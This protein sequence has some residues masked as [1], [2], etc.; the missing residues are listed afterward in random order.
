MKLM[1]LTATLGAFGAVTVALTAIVAPARAADSVQV[2]GTIVNLDGSKLTVKTREGATTAVAL[3]EGWELTG[4]AKAA[5]DDIK[6]GEF[7]GIA[8]TPTA[9]GGLLRRWKS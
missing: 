8:S 3:K 9:A 2:R 6:A 7:V 1:S 4:I 5:P